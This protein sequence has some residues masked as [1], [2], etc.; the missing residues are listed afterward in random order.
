MLGSRVRQP[1]ALR[2][3]T[4]AQ[5]AARQTARKLEAIPKQMARDARVASKPPSRQ[6]V[7]VDMVTKAG[8]RGLSR[9]E[10][11]ERMQRLF[12][13]SEGSITTSMYLLKKNR[14]IR[15]NAD[16]QWLAWR[17]RKGAAA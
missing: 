3:S 8:A 4:K 11:I 16:G 7:I 1:T 2:K 15:N 10:I 12:E 14:K 13:S 5:V 17:L 6:Q 9:A